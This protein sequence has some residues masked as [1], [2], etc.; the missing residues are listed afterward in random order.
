MRNAQ[1]PSLPSDFIFSSPADLRSALRLKELIG[2]TERVN[3]L[4]SGHP[5]RLGF[6][7]LDKHLRVPGLTDLDRE[8]LHVLAML[9]NTL[10]D[11]QAD[12][13]SHKRE[14]IGKLIS[15]KDAISLCFELLVGRMIVDR[16]ANTSSWQTFEPG[17]PDWH[18]SSPAFEV[19]CKLARSRDKASNYGKY[20]GDV[21]DQHPNPTG[22]LVAAVGFDGVLGDDVIDAMAGEARRHMPWMTRHREVSAVLVLG[23][24]GRNGRGRGPL[25]T[26][27]FRFAANRLIE[28]RNLNSSHPLPSDLRF[29]HGPEVYRTTLPGPMKSLTQRLQ[30]TPDAATGNT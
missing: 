25:G 16:H 23:R 5:L 27:G 20:L 11:H 1:P 8:H 22:P 24:S 21:A 17:L 10:F 15:A 30:E 18:A 28:I 19:E 2:G 14:L 7:A 6:R 12:W 9:A 13:A 3:N 29:G 26:T 4:A